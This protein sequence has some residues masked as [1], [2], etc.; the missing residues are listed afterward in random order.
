M[1][2]TFR[3]ASALVALL[4]LAA[5]VSACSTPAATETQP[6]AVPEETTVV[7][8]TTA[9]D[10]TG[11]S[12]GTAAAFDNFPRPK[13]KS[14]GKLT[15]AYVIRVSAAESQS[16]SFQQAQIECAHR[17]WTFVPLVIND[18]SELRDA[19]L[20]AINQD[21]D[22]M[23]LGNQE[24]MPSYKDVIAQ[25]REKGIGVYNNDNELVDGVI[26]NSTMPNGVSAMELLYTIGNTKGWT[27][28]IGFLEIPTIQVSNER[29]G[30]MAAVV[31][32]YAGMKVLERGDL[33]SDPS[34]VI[35]GATNFTSTWLQKYGSDLT[36]VIGFFDG[37]AEAAGQAIAAAGD[38][39]GEKTWTAGIDGGTQAW[40][41]IRDNTPFQFSYA[42]P[43]ELYTH[44]LFELMDE[45]QVKGLNPGDDGVLIAKSGDTIYSTGLVV[46]RTNVPAVGSNIHA[47]YNYY[48]GDPSDKSAWYN[49]TDGPGPYI[50]QGVEATPTATAK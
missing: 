7:S 50:I 48:G 47:L 22:V 6:T 1:S 29:I 23:L 40:A 2:K 25:A 17:G 39:T 19:M 30:P 5:L 13:I 8:P 42:Q 9:G 41:E 35:V 3:V 45:L 26:A 16:R 44:Q 49:W 20:N 37:A 11:S 31:S 36:G 38:P 46:T 14:D 32:S 15:V 27:G 12:S 21:V 34:G 28:G 24:S 43:F 4:M 18:A 10:T 33:T